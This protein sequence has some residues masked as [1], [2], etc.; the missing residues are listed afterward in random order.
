MLGKWRPRSIKPYLQ[1]HALCLEGALSRAAGFMAAPP[2]L[3]YRPHML[4]GDSEPQ[5]TGEEDDGLV[6]RP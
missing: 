2:D 1:T 6:L 5:E 4:L 3:C